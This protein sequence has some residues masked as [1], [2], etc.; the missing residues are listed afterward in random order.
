[1]TNVKR[2][3]LKNY[4]KCDSMPN[5]NKNARTKHDMQKLRRQRRNKERVKSRMRDEV[6][7][8]QNDFRKQ[9]KQTNY[10]VVTKVTQ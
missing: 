7:R 2:I 10:S 6:P 9:P 3:E 4:V 8:A 5:E 1:M